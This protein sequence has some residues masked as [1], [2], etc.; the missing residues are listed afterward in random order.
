MPTKTLIDEAALIADLNAHFPGAKAQSLSSW[1]SNPTQIGA[2]VSGEAEIE[3]GYCI[4]PS[5]YLDDEAYD[6][7]IHRGFEAWCEV[8]GWCVETYEFGTLWVVPLPS[9]QELAAWRTKCDAINEAHAQ[10]SV[11]LAGDELPL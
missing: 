7:Y 1:S 8:R 4:G 10:R 3:P 2:V 5:I 11:L 6:G 9:Q